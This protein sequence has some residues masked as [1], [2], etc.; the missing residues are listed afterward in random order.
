MSQ[1]SSPSNS[2]PRTLTNAEFA[3]AAKVI[4]AACQPVL[5]KMVD[6][7]NAYL[8]PHGFR[9]GADFNWVFDKLVPAEPPQ[10]HGGDPQ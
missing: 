1:P 3:L 9:V 4:D 7:I 6:E 8:K 5:Q 10:S 2:K